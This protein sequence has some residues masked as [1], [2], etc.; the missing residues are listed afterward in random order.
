MD[1][2]ASRF[3]G[4]SPYLAMS[5]NPVRRVD[6]DGMQDENAN[7]DEETMT[8]TVEEV[9]GDEDTEESEEVMT[10]TVEEVYGDQAGS[11][12]GEG[13]PGNSPVAA[14]VASALGAGNTYADLLRQHKLEGDFVKQMNAAK[15]DKWAKQAK[16]AGDTKLANYF[17]SISSKMRGK[18]LSARM[19]IA[20]A[21]LSGAGQAASGT[22][23]TYAGRTIEAA[24]A[25]YIAY[26]AGKKNPVAV[27][28][29][30]A[31]QMLGG[32]SIGATLSNSISAGVTLGEAAIT[33]ETQG[34]KKFSEE[35][36]SGKR[37]KV[38]QISTQ[39]GD[40]ILHNYERGNYDLTRAFK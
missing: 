36:R 8:F 22:S 11:A 24:A 21:A 32:P 10:F 33:K 13:G 6:P 35:A 5:D 3:P 2:K 30:A 14:K 29:D 17:K 12:N 26:A 18:T 7:E 23:Q 9:E 19:N 40:Y 25:T 38:F 39:I 34:M 31:S 4:K 15:F 16:A 1:P 37:G 28:I 20:G 27:G